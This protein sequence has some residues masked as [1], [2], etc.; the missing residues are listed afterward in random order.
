[1][2]LGICGVGRQI[3]LHHFTRAG[4]NLARI[5][6]AFLCAVC[7]AE[8]IHYGIMLRVDRFN[9]FLPGLTLHWSWIILWQKPIRAP[10][11]RGVV[12]FA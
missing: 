2:T 10:A 8:F 3:Q 11:A 6:L 7:L 4:R 1:M 9:I 12:F 5:R